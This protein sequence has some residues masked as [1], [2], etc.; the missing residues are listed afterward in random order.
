MKLA[1]LIERHRDRFVPMFDPELT[2]VNTIP[3]D[4][5]VSNREFDG[6]S[7]PAWDRAIEAKI[8]DAGAVAAVGGYLEK[9]SM[10]ES[11]PNFKGEEDRNVHIGV[12]VFIAAGTPVHAPLAGKVCCFANRQGEGDYGPVI[13]LRHQLDGVAFHSLYG[14]LTE[15]SLDRLRLGVEVAAG[16]PIARIGER[17][18]NGDW[19]PHLH[20]QLIHD[21][22]GLGDNYPGV[23]RADDLR[24]YQ[25]NCPSPNALI[26]GPGG[27]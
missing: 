23:A 14:H 5:S 11:T 15:A 4:L 9:R 27:T 10:Y 1:E 21:L 19:P 12:D 20:F 2:A 25:V 26:V 8:D 22:Q 13:I 7:G 16:S 3:I 6:M 17:P 24:F 18:L